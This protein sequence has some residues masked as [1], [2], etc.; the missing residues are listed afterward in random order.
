MPAYDFIVI[1][2][3]SAG[4][5]VASRLSENPAARVLLLEAGGPDTHPDI[6][7][8]ANWY[9]LFNT[10]RDWA[11]RTVPQVNTANRTHEWP[12]GKMLGGS[13]SM[14]VMIYIRGHYTD[15][16]AW[17]YAGNVGWDYQAVLPYFKKS[18]DFEGGPSY[19]HGTGGPLRVSFITN[20]N[21]VCACAVEAGIEL[22]YPYSDDFNGEQ[23]DGVGWCHLTVRAGQRC[24]AAMAFLSLALDRQNLTVQTHAHALRLEFEASRCVGVHYVQAGELRRAQAT[25][26]VIVSSGAIE[27][28]RLLMLSGVGNAD[29]LARLGIPVVAH[30]PDV[31]QNLQDHL[32]ARVN[33][34]AK[35]PI[36]P[37]KA[38]G[39]ESQMFWR[40]DP[41]R[42]GPDLQPAFAHGTSYPPGF[43][44]PSN[45][46]ALHAGLVRPLSRGWIQ[47]TSADPT[48]PLLIDPN[49]LSEEA[50]L[51]ALVEAVRICRELGAA[52]AFDDWR[53]RE[54][55]PG[56]D[57]KSAAEVR[58]Y[59]RKVVNTYFHPVGTC[60]MG[61]DCEA[62]VDPELRVQGVSGLRVADAS[63]MPTIVSGN[64]NAP[65]IMIGEKAADLIKAAHGMAPSPK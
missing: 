12:R 64:T 1:G 26:E 18:E 22:G 56:H 63:I 53:V 54:V 25:A 4:C 14:N 6:Q 3:G 13:S 24:S 57:V 37:A 29:E 16:D 2:G 62:V 33:Y 20:P 7:T 58:A 15:Y 11:Y 40:S 19:Y 50:D 36:P 41:R 31:G 5:V 27:S 49:Y 60:R 38:N 43:E 42:I 44:G 46:Y 23:T 61:L 17:A 21:P 45:S 28:P 65:A 39:V 8:P 48:A 32:L 30:S 55:I 35:L 9:R 51:R 52:R 10:E 47:L 59:I 34:E